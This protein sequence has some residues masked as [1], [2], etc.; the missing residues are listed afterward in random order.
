MTKFYLFFDASII[1]AK[2]TLRIEGMMCERCSSKVNDALMKVP[3][4]T[5]ASADHNKGKAVVLCDDS[6]KDEDL[7]MAVIDAGFKAKVKHGLF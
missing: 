4:V 2:R 3:G 1:M 7:C 5:D 6:V